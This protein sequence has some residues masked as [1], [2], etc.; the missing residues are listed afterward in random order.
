MQ[1]MCLG[2]RIYNDLYI[3]VRAK[4]GIRTPIGVNPC[5]MADVAIIEP[6]LWLMCSRKAM[7]AYLHREGEE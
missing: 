6:F 4:Q 5:I 3:T 7:S 2:V 1:W